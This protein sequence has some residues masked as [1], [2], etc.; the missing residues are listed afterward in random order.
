MN[1]DQKNTD[2]ALAA[3]GA[4]VVAD[5]LGNA[6]DA[7]DDGDS[8]GATQDPGAAATLCEDGSMPM[9]ADCIETYLTTDLVDNCSADGVQNNEPVDAWPPDLNDDQGVNVLDIIDGSVGV[10]AAWGAKTIDPEFTPRSDLYVDG[11][12]DI[13]DIIVPLFAFWGNSCK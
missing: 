3:V 10:F 6:C 8:L 2:K 11:S 12:I 7:D 5:E 13:L 4:T 9:W 1:T